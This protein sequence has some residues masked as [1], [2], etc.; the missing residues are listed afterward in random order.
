MHLQFWLADQIL[1]SVTSN[2]CFLWEWNRGRLSEEW[3]YWRNPCCKSRGESETYLKAFFTYI[4]LDFFR[5]HPSKYEIPK[6]NLEPV[7][8]SVWEPVWLI[9]SRIETS[10]DWFIFGTFVYLSYEYFEAYSLLHKCKQVGRFCE[11]QF[12][13]PLY[14]ELNSYL[15]VKY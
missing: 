15:L 6:E 1:S 14:S 9:C 10:Q 2:I 12:A 7:Y 13:L 4:H 3:G 8:R 11:N 5:P